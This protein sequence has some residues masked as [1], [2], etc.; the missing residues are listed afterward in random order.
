[1]EPTKTSELKSPPKKLVAFFRSSRDKWK[2]KYFNS[3]DQAI[4][5][6]NQVRAVENSRARWRSVAEQ[7]KREIKEL[8][9]QLKKTD[10]G[11]A[12]PAQHETS[13]SDSTT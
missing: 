9:E 8:K 3:R 4:L 13:S 5:L 12:N 2:T 10:D 1:M 7:A 11:P 6:A